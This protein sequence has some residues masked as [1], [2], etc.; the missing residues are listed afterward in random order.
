[1]RA[2]IS[3]LFIVAFN[4]VGGTFLALISQKGP[5]PGVWVIAETT[6]LPTRFA[7]IVITD[8]KGQYLIPD[9]PNVGFNVWARSY[10]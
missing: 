3:G 2:F 6:E 4:A 7:R 1:L 10:G 5:E 9:L 8:E